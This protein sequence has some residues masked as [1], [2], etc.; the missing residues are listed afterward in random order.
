LY[1]DKESREERDL[2]AAFAPALHHQVAMKPS[3]E[4]AVLC[5]AAHRASTLYH[6]FDF[7]TPLTFRLLLSLKKNKPMQIERVTTYSDEV[8]AAL[9]RLL[10]QLSPGT[11]ISEAWLRE[12]VADT[13][14]YLFVARDEEGEIPG[15]FTLAEE[16]IPTGLK[17]WLEDV[18]VEDL[19]RGRGY[20][21]AIVQYAVDVARSLGTLKLDL[22]SV[23]ER[24]A[25]NKLYQKWGFVRRKTNVYRL[26]FD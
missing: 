14:I 8:L 3:K 24:V 26:R 25:A 2:F 7:S 17:V 5:E 6:P 1:K 15:T 16:K 10:P 11:T 22:T 9:Q 21:R 4:H 20:G 13:G 19:S 23:P 12:I 18:V